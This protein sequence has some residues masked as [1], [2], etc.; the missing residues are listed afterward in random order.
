MLSLCMRFVRFI[1]RNVLS[2]KLSISDFSK[3]EIKKHQLSYFTKRIAEL[4]ANGELQKGKSGKLIFI[5]SSTSPITTP[6]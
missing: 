6:T 5:D 3:K 4:E 2:K 1:K